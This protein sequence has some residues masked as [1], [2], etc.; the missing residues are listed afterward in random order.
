VVRDSKLSVGTGVSLVLLGLFLLFNVVH[1]FVSLLLLVE[2]LLRHVF[3]IL[4]D[5]VIS[6]DIPAENLPLFL[7]VQT[8]WNLSLQQEVLLLDIGTG[9]VQV[10]RFLD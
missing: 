10:F 5:Q 1:H 8:L 7:L 6:K 9:Q 2:L 4:E 3:L